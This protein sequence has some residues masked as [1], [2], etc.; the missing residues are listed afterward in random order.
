LRFDVLLARKVRE[1]EA[2]AV[3][4]GS[5][6]RGKNTRRRLGAVRL[7]VDIWRMRKVVRSGGHGV[8]DG[9]GSVERADKYQ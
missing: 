9:S 1:I 3:R 2:D 6:S 5:V 8:C 7:N 4:R